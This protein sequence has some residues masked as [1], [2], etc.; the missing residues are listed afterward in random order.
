MQLNSTIEIVDVRFAV[1]MFFECQRKRWHFFK[2]FDNITFIKGVF[3]EKG[4]R[5]FRLR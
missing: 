4:T 2:I 5:K 1:I 3:N